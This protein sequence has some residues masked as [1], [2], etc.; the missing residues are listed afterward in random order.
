[1]ITYYTTTKLERLTEI[2][3]QAGGRIV[4]V[5]PP[6]PKNAKGGMEWPA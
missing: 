4:N 2:I 6:P 3:T 1:M 5:C